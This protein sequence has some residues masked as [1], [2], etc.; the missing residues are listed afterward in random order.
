VCNE[1]FIKQ[2]HNIPPLPW[3]HISHPFFAR[4]KDFP[5]GGGMGMRLSN[6]FVLS[7][8]SIAILAVLGWRG[9][10]VTTAIVGVCAS[11]TASRAAQKTGMVMASSKDEKSDTDAM[12]DKLK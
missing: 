2:L 10:D 4:Q 3:E 1:T 7:L 8:L 11:Y 5:L 6:S 12:I 9:V